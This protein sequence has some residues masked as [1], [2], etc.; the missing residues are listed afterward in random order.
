M[1][2]RNFLP[3]SLRAPLWG[4]RERWGLIPK[5]DDSCWREW[6]NTYLD[7][8]RANQ[9]EGIGTRVNDAGYVVMSSIELSGKRVLEIGAG[10]IRHIKNWRGVPAEYLLADISEDMMNFAKKKLKENNI[11]FR[12]LQVSRNQPLVLDDA[13]VDVIISFYS[14]EHLYP[15][16]SYLDDFKR[17]LKPGGYL[18]GAIPAEGGLAWGWGRLLTSRR[19]FKNNT[20]INPDKIICWEHPNFADQILSELDQ[21]FIREAVK[22]WPMP[23]LPFLDPNLIIRL[24]YRKL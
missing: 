6:Q 1:P 3:R 5:L 20:T 24:L 8:Y 16:R 9:R 21:L 17:V 18:I 4:D 2:I 15:L 22:H 19:W 12:T 7:F 11:T 14:L 23:W 13:S 10:D